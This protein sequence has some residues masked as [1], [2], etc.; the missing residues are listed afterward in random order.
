[1]SLLEPT[2]AEPV[3]PDEFQ[4]QAAERVTPLAEY[5][6]ST[7]LGGL[8][9]TRPVEA[10]KMLATP[11][12]DRASPA[13]ELPDSPVDS[14]SPTVAGPAAL[15]KEQ[16]EASPNARP[17]VPWDLGMT[18]ARAAALAAV[19]DRTAY[20]DSLIARSDAGWLG[21]TAGF[22]LGLGAGAIDFTNYIPL[23]G[24]ASKAAMVARFGRIG[25]SLLM[26]GSEATLNTGLFEPLAME[27]ARAEGRSYGWEEA[28]ADILKNAL[29][30]AVLGTA[31][32]EAARLFG[33]GHAPA[34]ETPPPG[35]RELPRTE[36]PAVDGSP[37]QA[38]VVPP[39][40]VAPGVAGLSDHA[41]GEVT[42]GIDDRSLYAEGSP[43]VRFV[44]TPEEAAALRAAGVEISDSGVISTDS[45]IALMDERYQR[46][47][48][49]SGVSA[50]PASPVRVDDLMRRADAAEIALDQ[51]DRGEPVDVGK[52]LANDPAVRAPAPA[53]VLSPAAVGDA[54]RGIVGGMYDML[55]ERY[56]RGETTEAGA[57]SLVLQVAKAIDDRGRPLTR[58][59]FPAL[60]ADVMAARKA[61]SGPEFQAATRRVIDKWAPPRAAPAEVA[62]T[63][64]GRRVP[65]AYEVVEA[66]TLVASHT[67]DMRVNP[68]FPAELQPRDR[69]RAASGTQVAAMAA[70]LEP[71][72]LGR[73]ATASEGAP[74]VGPDGV[75]E[76][77]N[78]RVLAIRKAY[79][80]GQP[81]GAAY[82]RFL[83]EAGHPE[84]AGM[85]APV[86]VRRRTGAMTPDERAAFAREANVSGVAQMGTAERAGSD[87]AALKPGH[88]ELLASADLHAAA[89]RPFVRAF[90]GTL[91]EGERAGLLTASG[92]LSRAGAERVRNAVLAKAFGDAG[93]VARLAEE[94]ES[95]L[96]GLGQALAGVAPEW[97]KMRAEVAAGQIAPEGD[98]TAALLEALH[99]IIAAKAAGNPP[100]FA[101]EQGDM[102]GGGLSRDGAAFLRAFLVLDRKGGS[103]VLGREKLAA[104]L[105]RYVTE[106]RKQPPGVD[107]F[108]NRP[109]TPAEILEG[110]RGPMSL[111]TAAPEP[112]HPS[113]AE[114]AKRVGKGGD[115]L[116]T[117]KEDAKLEGYDKPLPGH[118]PKP[119]TAET[120]TETGKAGK[121][122]NA[123]PTPREKAA[124]LAALPPELQ[125]I[126]HMRREGVLRPEDEAALAAAEVEA[127]RAED[128]AAAWQALAGCVMR[129]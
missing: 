114:A 51:L 110:R 25:G 81:G 126:E 113:V 106:A 58:D 57:P 85:E 89:N 28:G 4:R 7:L 50:K 19:H 38:G 87:A 14:F 124:A 31:V 34:V 72:L 33:F 111:A 1:M 118:E 71:A 53:A 75:V 88:L 99:A 121:A 22:G 32:G 2:L 6:S 18:E 36:L 3:T 93:L 54:G 127:Q 117:F 100:H 49:R 43:G 61:G 60:A 8:E 56:S 63:S 82:R 125:E 86:L 70:N 108:G 102:L 79:G 129:G 84:A 76:S 115:E 27:A 11:Q 59:E 48:A 55:H 120:E 77:G 5:F 68:A 20:R 62:I 74:I 40:P 78:A 67:E 23:L 73:S 98:G 83:V 26:H 90:L 42:S 80:E 101:L 16:Y 95:G 47:V 96:N 116:A 35:R 105:D 103:R 45:A 46:Q 15:T 122:G 10:F 66:H 123:E 97:A 29:G 21:Q 92:E 44:G 39:E 9:A 64:A 112:P 12:P 52:V 30:G 109:A 104:L 107:M 94:P 24:P 37:R 41:L 91:P 128:Y 119:E 13:L 17:G 65:V 69:T